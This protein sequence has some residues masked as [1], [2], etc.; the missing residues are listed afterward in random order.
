M[1]DTL[2]QQSLLELLKKSTVDFTLGNR[3]SYQTLL[4]SMDD[5]RFV[6]MGEAT[7]GSLE[8]YQIRMILSDYLIREKG[9]HAIAIEGDWTSVYSLNRYL[10][11]EMASE[12]VNCLLKNFQRFPQW[13]WNNSLM[14][15]FLMKLR[16]YNDLQTKLRV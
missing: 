12:Q 11:G 1:N 6:L 14:A 8:F 9:F 7:H 4:T 16:Q 15:D 3:D 5:A 10:Q 2:A 13:L